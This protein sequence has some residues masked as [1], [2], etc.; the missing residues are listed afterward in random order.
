MPV[1]YMESA[2]SMSTMK[3]DVT[4]IGDYKLKLGIFLEIHNSNQNNR[5]D[6]GWSS[7][8]RGRVASKSAAFEISAREKE[9]ILHSGLHA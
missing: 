4:C 9:V 1:Q 7:T 5:G 2:W 3:D 6:N 8:P